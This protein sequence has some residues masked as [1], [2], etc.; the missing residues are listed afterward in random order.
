MGNRNDERHHALYQVS[1]GIANAKRQI[2]W[3][4]QA[5]TLLGLLARTPVVNIAVGGTFALPLSVYHSRRFVGHIMSRSGR[6]RFSCPQ[7]GKVVSTAAA[8]AGK[9]GKCPECNQQ[10]EIP[11]QSPVGGGSSSA[12]HS[13]AS[14]SRIMEKSTTL[15]I[16][17][18]FLSY[19]SRHFRT[20]G[21][22]A[23]FQNGFPYRTVVVVDEANEIGLP[24]PPGFTEQRLYTMVGATNVGTIDLA[25]HETEGLVN[26]SLF[27]M[28]RERRKKATVEKRAFVCYPIY[29]PELPK[30]ADRSRA[31]RPLLLS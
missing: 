2:A 4:V 1:R 11:A 26:C 12:C 15:D 8:N 31:A 25:F 23:S 5:R 19:A 17:G 3:C 7:C 20:I 10:F 29:S 24:L 13:T 18:N 28:P 27:V 21:D 16:V 14:F 9:Q 30:C 6:I 22:V